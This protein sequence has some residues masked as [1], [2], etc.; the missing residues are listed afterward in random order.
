MVSVMVTGGTGVLGQEVVPRLL[1]GGHEV[2]VLTRR[3][4]VPLPDGVRRMAGNLAAGQGLDAAARVAEVIV[5]LATRPFR[6]ARVDVGGTRA[7][8]DA[9][10]RCGGDPAPGLC[11]DRRSRADPLVLLPPQTGSGVAPRVIHRGRYVRW[12]GR[13]CGGRGLTVLGMIIDAGLAFPE[14]A[15]SEP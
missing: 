1:A 5:H 11:L 7:L 2:A 3:R 6:P 4:A 12:P 10:K 15:G 9:V 13:A 8:L 14:A